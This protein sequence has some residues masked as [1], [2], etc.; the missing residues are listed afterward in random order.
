MY[1]NIDGGA[2]NFS[3]PRTWTCIDT[4]TPAHMH[5]RINSTI[6]VSHCCSSENLILSSPPPHTHTHYHH[7]TLICRACS[8]A[9]KRMTEERLPTCLSGHLPPAGPSAQQQSR[10]ETGGEITRNNPEKASVRPSRSFPTA[11]VTQRALVDQGVT[12]KS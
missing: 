2:R 12:A 3:H 7:H 1:G 8:T 11:T 6:T 9:D 10:Q 4:A 5:H